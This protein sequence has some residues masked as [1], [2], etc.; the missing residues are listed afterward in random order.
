MGGEERGHRRGGPKAGA[1]WAR[2]G[3][4][5]VGSLSMERAALSQGEG[6]SAAQIAWGLPYQ[7]GCHPQPGTFGRDPRALLPRKMSGY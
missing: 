6:G 1:E 2:G 5:R 4:Q 7:T 3:G